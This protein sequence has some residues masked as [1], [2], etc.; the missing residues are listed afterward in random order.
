MMP[1]SRLSIRSAYG[2]LLHHG[3]T[4]RRFRAQT[5]RKLARSACEDV[6]MTITRPAATAPERSATKRTVLMC[7]PTYFTVVYSIN[8]WMFPQHPTNTDLAVEQWQTLYD[9]YVGL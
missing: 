5:R 9:T 4:G 3:K 8:P 6:R 1:W 7:R 2:D